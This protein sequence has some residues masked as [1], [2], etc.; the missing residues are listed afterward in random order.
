MKVNKLS[1][2]EKPFNKTIIEKSLKQKKIHTNDI[3]ILEDKIK[4]LDRE[5]SI[6]ERIRNEVQKSNSISTHETEMSEGPNSFQTPCQGRKSMPVKNVRNTLGHIRGL[7]THM[8]DLVNQDPGTEAGLSQELS[9][10]VKMNQTLTIEETPEMVKNI[11]NIV[12]ETS[13]ALE[14][15]EDM[16]PIEKKLRKKRSQSKYE[17]V[18]RETFHPKRRRVYKEDLEYY[19]N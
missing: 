11:K 6:T 1:T 17:G 2:R 18:R 4:Q 15:S 8:V 12:N 13:V 16:N 5:I 19:H 7:I 10:L 14:R 9:N 3:K